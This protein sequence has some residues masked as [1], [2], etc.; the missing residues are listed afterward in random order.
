MFSHQ[1]QRPP[2]PTGSI[3]R[4]TRLLGV[5]FVGLW[6]VACSESP[7]ERI[8]GKWQAAGT[9]DGNVLEF[10]QDGTVTFNEAITGVGINGEYTFLN[11]QKVKIELSGILAIAG[12]TIYT[13]SFSDNQ[14]SLVTQNGDEVSTYDKVD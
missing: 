13:I 4:L 14:M 7:Q 6:L 1:F 5:I 9:T 2:M 3:G 12:A 8:V 11:D 10:Y